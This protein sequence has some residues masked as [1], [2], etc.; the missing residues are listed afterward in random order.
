MP[1]WLWSTALKG[2]REATEQSGVGACRGEGNADPAFRFDDTG[3]DFQEP[4]AERFELGLGEVLDFGNGVA[5]G[6]QQPIGGSVQH[7]A[8]L[9]SQGRSAAGSIG[10]ELGL[11]EFYQVLD[12][13]ILK[14]L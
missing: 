13:T 3:G 14:P 10:G 11:M 8:N 2:G 6:E 9:V 4:K 1:C 7:Q 5:D 12:L